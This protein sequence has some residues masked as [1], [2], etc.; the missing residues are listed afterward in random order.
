MN[1]EY[2]ERLSHGAEKRF[3]DLEERILRDIVRRIKKTGE[4]TST[5]DWQLTKYHLL[6]NS[7]EQIEKEIKK[8]IDDSYAMT[9]E[10]YDNVINSQYVRYKALYEQV[11]QE[12]IPFDKNLE[13]LQLV[14]GFKRQSNTDLFNITK[15]LGFMMPDVWTGKLHFTSVAQTYNNILDAAMLDIASGGV[16]L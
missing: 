5:A 12:F 4:I 13:L 1:R 2:S 8:C 11:N 15:S 16:R 6:G 3:L 9:F 14:E 10:S 7:T